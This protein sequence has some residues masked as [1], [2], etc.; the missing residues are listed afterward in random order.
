HFPGH[1]DTGVDSHLALPTL[2]GSA[3][4]IAA[5]ALPPFRAAIDAG[6]RAIMTGHLLVSALDPDV[7]ATMSSRILVELLREE[8]GFD[9][10]IITDGIQ[11]R[12]VADR[13]GLAG[14]AVR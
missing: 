6:V 14:A 10:L 8:L 12:A 13:Y 1:G 5:Q 2:E 9:G 11:M 4:S 3:E 7:P